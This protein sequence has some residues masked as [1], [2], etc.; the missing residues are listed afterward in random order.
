MDGLFAE[1]KAVKDRSARA[2]VYAQVQQIIQD[3]APAAFLNFP[4]ELQAISTNLQGLARMHYR[5]L[6]KFAHLFWLKP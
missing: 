3:D 6:F 2:K 5:D 1:T 4:M